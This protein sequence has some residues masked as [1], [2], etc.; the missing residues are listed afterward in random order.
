MR[1]AIM[2]LLPALPLPAL[3]QEA[4]PAV[5]LTEHT[6]LAPWTGELTFTVPAFSV[7]HQVRL[8]LEARIDA[9]R[10]MGSN[11]W[12]RIAVNGTWLAEDAL[13]NKLNEFTTVGGTDLTWVR[14]DRFRILYSP[15][16]EAALDPTNPYSVP[17][18][19]P[20]RFV[21]DITPYVRPGENTLVLEHLK[22]LE[23][24]STMVIRN[25]QVEVG[26]AIPPPRGEIAPAPTGPLPTFVA[27]EPRLVDMT[28]RLDPG[29]G[30]VLEA[31][32]RSFEVATRMSL[33]GGKWLQTPPAGTGKPIARGAEASAQ[34]PGGVWR[35]ERTVRVLDDHVAV[36]DTLTNTADTLQGL[37]VEHACSFSEQ[38]ADVRIAGRPIRAAESRA[39]SPE[40]PSVYLRWPD[41]GLA[42][43]AEDDVL[44]VHS[45]FFREPERFGLRDDRLGLAGGDSVTL[46]WS[47][48][49]TPAGDYWDFVN[50]VRRNW[51]V[52][53][54]I[55][56]P[57]VFGAGIRP[58]WEP[59][60]YAQWMR[61]RD[62]KITC[63]GI[64]KYPDGTYAH[65]TGILFAPEFVAGERDWITKMR[66]AAP[67]TLPLCYFHCFCCTEPGGEQKYADSRLLNAAGEHV[68]YPYS[69]RLPLYVPTRENS[70]GKAL[71]GFVDTILDTIGAAGIYWDEMSHS[72]LWWAEDMAWDGVSVLIDPD[73]HEVIRTITS[74]PLIT[75]PLKLDIIEHVRERGCFLMANT[76]AA[77]R[78]MTQ[79]KIVRFVETGSFSAVN[80][81][82]LA[83]PLGLGNHH[84]DDTP[85]DSA[86][87]C[88]G[89]LRHSGLYYGHYYVREPAQWNFYAPMFPFTPV[90]LREGMV[91]GED[92]IATSVSGR[93]GFPD[94]A[95]AEVYVV[96][97]DGLRVADP[98][99]TEVV[100]DGKR[101]YEIRMPGDQFAIVVRAG[102]T[103]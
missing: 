41:C 95:A 18:G 77:T 22:V 82:H 21:L 98:D 49:P 30:I 85:G 29:G 61:A 74:V 87:N 24:P 101:L 17:G 83:C 81:T 16:F 14:G 80:E 4:G 89:I 51:G 34:W 13:L 23:Q 73:T 3:A 103:P 31:G 27:Q 60:E 93:F 84:G 63:G 33:P 52:N 48:Y 39:Y 54:T 40:H 78:T 88:L 25:V 66:T 11:P 10:L 32:G 56:G 55:P 45:T 99:V 15:D 7:E 53:F 12:L 8:S 46:E 75:Q 9:P 6:S 69:Y 67:E 43:L 28:V 59:V 36:A 64:A 37:I 65:G 42:L 19:D 5:I 92:R 102:L 76:Q 86:A 2:T 20:Y 71:W 35:V 1:I 47:L 50:A 97:A 91:I 58:G 62:V 72:V 44:R 96:G 90:E 100:E 68:G 57:F 26:R 38:P 70:Y 94:G 79:Q